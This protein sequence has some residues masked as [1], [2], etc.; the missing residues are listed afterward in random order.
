MDASGNQL[1]WIVGGEDVILRV[2][3]VAHIRIDSPIIGFFVKDKLGQS[4]FGDSSWITYMDEPV[5]ASE[6]QILTAEFAFNMPRLP[7]G[8]YSISVA[9]A[10]GTQTEHI[11][12]QWIHDAINFKSESTSVSSGIVGI[13]MQHISLISENLHE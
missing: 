5:I 8:N 11:Q 7:A 1:S 4:L 12:H 9:V 2:E 10:S 3:I 13:P 6:N